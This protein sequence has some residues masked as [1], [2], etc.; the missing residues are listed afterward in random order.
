MTLYLFFK[1]MHIQEPVL[2]RIDFF[3]LKNLSGIDKIINSVVQTDNLQSGEKA[4]TFTELRFLLIGKKLVPIM[5]C[6]IPYHQR[7]G[8]S[9]Q[10]YIILE[11]FFLDF[12]QVFVKIKNKTDNKRRR[13][14]RMNKDRGFFFFFYLY[15]CDTFQRF[16]RTKHFWISVDRGFVSVSTV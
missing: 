6:S 7:C 12:R 10:R 3:F 9:S 14:T 11:R 16:E 15:S 8:V 5:V 2:N 1:S 13:F 4:I